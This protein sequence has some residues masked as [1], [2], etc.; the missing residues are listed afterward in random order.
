[1][2]N[3]YTSIHEDEMF[4]NFVAQNQYIYKQI[5]SHK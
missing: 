5:F 3:K 2:Q 4:V 1:M